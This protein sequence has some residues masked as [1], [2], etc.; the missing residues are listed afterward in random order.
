M[1]L[2]HCYD[3]QKTGMPLFDT[4]AIITERKRGGVQSQRWTSD[5][6]FWLLWGKNSLTLQIRLTS[7]SFSLSLS[8]LHLFS[9]CF[10]PLVL[11]PPASTPSSSF[12]LLPFFLLPPFQSGFFPNPL[13]PSPPPL[14]FLITVTFQDPVLCQLFL[15]LTVTHSG[16]SIEPR[17]HVRKQA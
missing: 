16:R 15:V 6:F 9:T 10:L 11:P 2:P 14:C 3:D 17:F 12:L 5:N 1:D 7:A 13:F 4:G 8:S